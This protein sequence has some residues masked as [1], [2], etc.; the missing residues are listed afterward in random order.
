MAS[1][2]Q[3]TFLA[4]AQMVAGHLRLK[5]ADRWSPHVCR[6]KYHS[7]SSEF[8]E[9]GD[10]QFMWAAE[11]WIQGTS[12]EAFHR[13]PTWAELMAPLY[14]T[15]AGRANR[16][17]G[18]RPDLPPFVQFKP[19]QLSLLPAARQSLLNAPD[20]QNAAAYQ[21]VGVGQLVLPEA[22]DPPGLSDEEWEAYLERVREGVT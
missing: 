11:Q 3:E 10:A 19:A 16:S 18:P 15:E 21:V 2:S 22:G 6:L 17:W 1:L 13:F 8:P 7:F 4:V 5:E 20:Q 14:R 12:P 9:V